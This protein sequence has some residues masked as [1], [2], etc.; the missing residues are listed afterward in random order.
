MN[1]ILFWVIALNLF[2]IIKNILVKIQ[3]LRSNNSIQGSKCISLEKNVCVNAVFKK[4]FFDKKTFCSRE[5]CPGFTIYIQGNKIK[6]FSVWNVF[7]IVIDVFPQILSIILVI[8][9]LK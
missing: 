8:I 4:C 5:K 9:Q 6:I 2:S 7:M 3:E 1:K